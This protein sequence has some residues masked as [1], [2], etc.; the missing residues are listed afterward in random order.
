MS[1][2]TI[3]DTCKPR[4]RIYFRN[5][6]WLDLKIRMSE[7][8]INEKIELLKFAVADVNPK[9]IVLLSSREDLR[10][11]NESRYA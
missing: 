9:S 7:I 1:E 4:L 2:V 5:L 10:T 6:T 8:N 11:V 3:A